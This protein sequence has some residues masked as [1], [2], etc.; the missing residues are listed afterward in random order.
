LYPSP[1]EFSSAAELRADAKAVRARFKTLPAWQPPTPPAPEPKPACTHRPVLHAVFIISD[2]A[3]TDL[4]R[5]WVSHAPQPRPIKVE[6]IQRIIARY[7]DVSR[8]D[9]ISSRR[10]A[11]VSFPRQV[12]MYLVRTLTIRTFQEIG[13]LF[14]DRDHTTVLHA[15]RKIARKRE[16]DTTFAALMGEF[17]R[18]I[19]GWQAP[20]EE[21][22]AT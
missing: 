7:Y 17:V 15:V 2:D 6:D 11:N 14:G 22:G 8:L 1:R 20:A 10:T 21:M 19:E 18:Q 3:Y 4:L 5:G 9:L 13:R 12:A 16:T